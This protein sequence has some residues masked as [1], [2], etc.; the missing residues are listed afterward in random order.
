MSSDPDTVITNAEQNVVSIPFAGNGDDEAGI[1][2]LFEGV[3]D[4]IRE[5]LIPVKTI[6]MHG[7]AISGEIEVDACVSTLQHG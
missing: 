6:A 7:A 4:E 5:D 2:V 3:F 1:G